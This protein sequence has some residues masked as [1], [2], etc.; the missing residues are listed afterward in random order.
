MKEIYIMLTQVG[1]LVSKSIKLYTKAKYNH[2]S[3]GID[4][5]LKVFYSFARRVRYLPVIGGF[6]TEIINEG[7][8]K[9]YPD[10]QCAIYALQVDDKVYTKV[11][12]L[13]DN[14]IKEGH[15]YRY[16]I[17]G[18]F[19]VVI[20]RPFKHEYRNTC[21]EFIAK[22]LHDAGI[23]SFKKEFSLVRPDELPDIP[24]LKLV[25]EGRMQELDIS[26]VG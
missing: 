4:P 13:L 9:Y 19:G 12:S 18:L 20:N 2:S 3:I 22:V 17:L 1:T 26:K 7:M 11:V 5:E 6:I 23:Y 8:F 16:N 25:F 10:T 15:R 21:A 24:G 14:Y